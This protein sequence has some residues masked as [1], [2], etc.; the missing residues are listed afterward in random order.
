[1][2]FIKQMSFNRAYVVLSIGLLAGSIGPIIIRY[3][4]E[5]AMPATVIT[6]LRLVISSG[7]LLPLMLR[8]YRHDVRRMTRREVG[9]TVTAGALFAVGIMLLVA[10]LEHT[11]VL[12]NQVLVGTNP[13]W[14]A[15]VEVF[16]LKE[17][18]TRRVWIGVFITLA[19][20][21]LVAVASAGDTTV[22]NGVLLGILMALGSAMLSAFYFTIGRIVRATVSIVP[23]M[24]ML[25]T[26]GAIVGLV[27]V[28]FVSDS[29]TGYPLI[30][31]FW[32]VVLTIVVQ[33][34]AH[35]SFNYA[36]GF[37]TATS[38][39]IAGQVIPV[40]SAIWGFLILGEVPLIL[41]V[42]GS[43]VI[44]IGVFMVIRGQSIEKSKFRHDNP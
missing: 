29:L 3:T 40:A 14:V 19:G 5:S 6:T 27:I 36:L 42:I 28:F 20:G 2:T 17:L 9:L 26:S 16:I 34:G 23:Y 24:W 31:Y 35:V 18:L 32:V 10:S 37:I 12:I 41:Q 44:I 7:L 11:S 30:G 1:M 15:L 21:I 25:Y 4:Q 22:S 38:V 39:T 33:I 8:N 13:L 43:G